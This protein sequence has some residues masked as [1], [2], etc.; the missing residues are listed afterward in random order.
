MYPLYEEIPVNSNE[1]EDIELH[2]YKIVGTQL[3]CL[4]SP[5]PDFDDE[6]YYYEEDDPIH[7]KVVDYKLRNPKSFEDMNA[8]KLS[9]SN[10]YSV[11]RLQEIRDGFQGVIAETWLK[12]E[13]VQMNHF[14]MLDQG[15]LLRIITN[16]NL[17]TLNMKSI[18]IPE[19]INNSGFFNLELGENM[20][21]RETFSSNMKR[22][23]G[24]LELYNGHSLAEMVKDSQKLQEYLKR[25][26]K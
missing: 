7:L 13:I 12:P 22:L 15:E 4:Y 17:V 26:R 14:E 20:R 3:I 19:F 24:G 5:N 16:A 1:E 9:C 11:S 6:D 8:E 25:M 21:V 23:F 18:D 10:I 2:C